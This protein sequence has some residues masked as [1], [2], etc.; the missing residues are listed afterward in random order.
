[1]KTLEMYYKLKE[2]KQNIKTLNKLI[3]I[4]KRLSKSAV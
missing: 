4:L 3:D 1:M 2:I